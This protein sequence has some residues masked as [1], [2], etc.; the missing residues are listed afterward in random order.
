MDSLT[1]LV[2]GALTPL[3]FR[4]APRRGL[5]VAFGIVAGEFPDIDVLISDGTPEAFL[6]MHRGIT[7]ALFWQPVMALAVVFPF[8]ILIRAGEREPAGSGAAG[9]RPLGLGPMFWAALLALC[10]HI[11][12][13]CMTTFGTQALLPFSGARLWNPAM[14][15]VDLLCTLPPLVMLMSILRREFFPG[16]AAPSRPGSIFSDRTRRLARMGVAWFFLY[17]LACLGANALHTQYI[18]RLCLG[19]GTEAQADPGQLPEALRQS[20]FCPL[21]SAVP[22][23][24]VEGRSVTLLTEPFSPL[25]WKVVIE[26]GPY[27][28]VGTTVIWPGKTVPRLER[29]ARADQTLVDRLAAEQPL[30]RH[31]AEFCAFM[32]QTARPADPETRARYGEG[33]MEYSF[34]DLRYVSSPRGLLRWAGHDAVNFVLEARVT[35][36]GELT[37]YRYLKD[38]TRTDEPWTFVEPR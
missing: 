19:P 31:F 7:H 11:Y 3:A 14:F 27:Y 13:D 29:F 37:A 17:P 8:Y 5:V 4:N 25:D 23:A 33:S 2:A 28:L 15:I 12:L 9:E 34:M 22:G 35:G 16:T 20:P 30:F 38:S 21:P 36:A 26:D 24:P 18:A 10:L 32:I 1:H 6:A